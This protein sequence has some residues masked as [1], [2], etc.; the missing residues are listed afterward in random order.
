MTTA[1]IV[2]DGFSL[3][4]RLLLYTSILLTPAQLVSGIENHLPSNIGFLAFNWYNQIAWYRAAKAHQLH[5]LCLLPIHFNTIFAVTY[6]G[7]IT[8]GN[9]FT[10]LIQYL[11]IN[12]VLILNTVVAWTCVLENLKEGLGVYEFF[13]FGW[14]TL[15]GGWYKFMVCWQVFNTLLVIGILAFAFL[16]LFG[17]VEA[18]NGTWY[19]KYI[20]IPVGSAMMLCVIWPL[21]VW[22]ELVVARNTTESDTD[23]LSVWFFVGQVGALLLPSSSM[24]FGCFRGRRG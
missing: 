2:A 16:M 8:S 18:E 6:F 3:T 20:A 5:A 12:G 22:V 10:G 15:S 7:G 11:A 19:S 1:E 24:I 17:V 23:M 4:N 9:V 21:I 13:F 14:R